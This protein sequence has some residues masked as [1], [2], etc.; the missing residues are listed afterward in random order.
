M[1]TIIAMTII[2][3]IP[4]YF[5]MTK[6]EWVVK[7][8]DKLMEENLSLLASVSEKDKML[9]HFKSVAQKC[10]NDHNAQIEKNQELKKEIEHLTEDVQVMYSVIRNQSNNIW[11][12]FLKEKEEARY[13]KK[14]KPKSAKTKTA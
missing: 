4:A 12:Y 1:Y 9:E 10:I 5:I 11:K 6:I 8:N 3:L 13:L 2:F 7:E 14:H